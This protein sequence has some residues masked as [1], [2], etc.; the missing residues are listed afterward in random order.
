MRPHTIGILAGMGARSTAPFVELVVDECQAQYGARHDADY[1]HMMIYSLPAPFYFD[2]PMDG[3]AVAAAAAEGLRRLE[4]TGVDFIAM[5]CNTA[6]IF[7][8]ELAAAV[9]VPV[10][11]MIEETAAAVPEGTRAPAL[12]ATRMTVEAG[13]Y[14]R[15]LKAAG[16]RLLAR[17]EW[18]RRMDELLLAIKASPDRAAPQELWDALAADVAAA[19]ADTVILGCTDLNAVQPRLPAGLRLLDAT[20]CLARATVRRY[21]KIRGMPGLSG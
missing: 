10:L 13:L 6:H 3:A 15:A 1:P 7:Y 2:R 19:G 4:S 17:D 5:P 14:E 18:Q 12:F 21:L 20:A 16:L 9:G 11:N 8:D